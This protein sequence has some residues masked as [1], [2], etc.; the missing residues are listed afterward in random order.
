MPCENSCG[1]VRLVVPLH[2]HF[3]VPFLAHAF[4]GVLHQWNWPWVHDRCHAKASR[5]AHAEG[6]EGSHQDSGFTLSTLLL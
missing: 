6:G 3:T 4:K 1:S 2:L 5:P